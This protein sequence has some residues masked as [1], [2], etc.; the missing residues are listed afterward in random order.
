MFRSILI[1]CATFGSVDAFT[2]VAGE[3]P[4]IVET[5]APPVA[6]KDM[7]SLFEDANRLEKARTELCVSLLARIQEKDLNAIDKENGMWVLSRLRY[8]PAINFTISQ[9]SIPKSVRFKRIGKSLDII[10]GT[11]ANFD[12]NY[13][14]PAIQALLDHGSAAVPPLVKAYI[15]RRKELAEK[16]QEEP[17]VVLRNI[18]YTLYQLDNSEN[19]L[20][21]LKRAIE[22]S[23]LKEVL[24]IEVEAMVELRVRINEE[25]KRRR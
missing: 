25:V 7:K 1:L 19:A 21:Y 23:R 5:P 3:K 12:L 22:G 24:G 14:F 8:E 4:V 18:E 15:A 6:V 11:D 17:D 2:V 10:R 20:L 9:I 16:P 13:N